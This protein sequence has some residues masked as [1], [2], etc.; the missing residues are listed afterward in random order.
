MND[1]PVTT[2]NLR[3]LTFALSPAFRWAHLRQCFHPYACWL[4]PSPLLSSIAAAQ[5]G[6]LQITLIAEYCREHR[7]VYKD[8]CP[9]REKIYHSRSPRRIVP[10][11][12]GREC[13]QRVVSQSLV[14]ASCSLMFH[15]PHS[16]KCTLP[17]GSAAGVLSFV[18]TVHLHRTRSES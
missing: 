1:T 2:S 10:L 13:V 12:A 6:C 4:M 5:R 15:L 14:S 3:Y 8:K 7:D 16:G 17:R 11:Q 18:S 9:S